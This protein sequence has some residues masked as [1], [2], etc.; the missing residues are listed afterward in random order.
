MWNRKDEHKTP[1]RSG[2]P[3]HPRFMGVRILWELAVVSVSL[4]RST[5]PL[6]LILVL[7]ILGAVAMLSGGLPGVQG[8][9]EAVTAT[10]ETQMAAALPGDTIVRVTS[11]RRF[12]P[13]IVVGI[14]KGETFE[15]KR[16]AVAP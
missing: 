11:V 10:G 8:A 13:G 5:L 7:F 9:S 15:I 6:K 3:T 4:K 12:L 2:V 16:I 14:G 1:H